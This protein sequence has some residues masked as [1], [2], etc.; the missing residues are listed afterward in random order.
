MKDYSEWEAVLDYEQE[1]TWVDSNR[2][3]FKHRTPEVGKTLRF[4][5]IPVH[6]F[7][8]TSINS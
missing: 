4:E 2:P 3:W 6:E 7:I 5:P 8:K 1:S